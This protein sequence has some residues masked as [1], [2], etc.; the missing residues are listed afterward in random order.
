MLLDPIFPS[1]L[2][3]TLIDERSIGNKTY[4]CS[5][6]HAKFWMGEK[7]STSTKQVSRFSLCF[8]LNALQHMLHKINPM[9]PTSNM[10]LI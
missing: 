6:Y 3:D 10:R 5:Y 1:R 7:L 2:N 8:R 9:S 4:H